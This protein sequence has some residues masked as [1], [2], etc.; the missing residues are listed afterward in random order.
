MPK[1]SA[2]PRTFFLNEQHELAP[3]E[4][5]GGGG[6]TKFGDIDWGQR[7]QRIADSL[8]RAVGKVRKSPD[9]LREE[10]YFLAAVPAKIPKLTTSKQ[11]SKTGKP[12]EIEETP[13]FGGKDSLV[14]RRLGVD[15]LQ[16]HPDGTATVHVGSPSLG[17]LV[18]TSR[19]LGDEG[20]RQQARLS[21]IDSFEEVPWQKRIDPGWFAEIKSIPLVEFVLEFQP[22]LSRS[23]VRA[24]IEA[25]TT[26]L[27]S[28]ENESVSRAGTDFSGRSWIRGRARPPT[29]RLFAERFQSIQSIHPPLWTN[30][31]ATRRKKSS[32]SSAQQVRGDVDPSSLPVVAVVDA[33]VPDQHVSLER[34]KRGKYT[35]PGLPRYLG[36]HGTFVASRVVFGDPSSMEGTA[37]PR[38]SFYDVMLAEEADRIDDKS[39]AEAVDAVI[40]NAPDVR[41]FNMSFDQRPLPAMNDVDR[42]ER[43]ALVQDLDNLIF[44]RDILVVV[45]AGNSPPGITPENEYPDHF[46]E[47]SWKL[48]PWASG[49]NT[50]TCGSLI[51]RPNPD[52]MV[53]QVGYPSP[54]TRSGPGVAGAPVPEFAAS[55]GECDRLWSCGAGMGVLGLNNEGQWED[56]C[57]TS[58]AAP[59]LAQEAAIA[60]ALLQNACPPGA[61]TFAVTVKAFLALTASLVGSPPA[62]KKW[63]RQTLGRGRASAERL[64][65]PL[66]DSAI[67]LW[68]TTLE[69]TNAI[70]RVNVPVPEAWLQA[71]GAARMKLVC[72]W[73]PPVN[74]SVPDV[75][76]CRKVNVRFRCG[77]DGPALTGKGRG[78]K[79]YPLVER[80]YD[81]S[82]A[83]RQGDGSDWIVEVSYEQKAE[84]AM[85]IDFSPQQRV[86]LAI[87]LFDDGEAPESPQAH[88]QALEIAPTLIRL[89][90][91]PVGVG[92]PVMIRQRV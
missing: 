86:A 13:N 29:L 33:G 48:G 32:A 83:E 25:L 2:E 27:D 22:V 14:F 60:I 74:A 18:S 62:A 75:W 52:G 45:A 90:V 81:L 44:A 70:A 63:V 21:S 31:A 8:L 49:L 67:F 85:G 56:R 15:L 87:E 40:G 51:A 69:G 77:P 6:H 43:L 58:Y 47:T 39:V 91:P 19:N 88:V 59:L 78:H 68:Q 30:L 4:P 50:L 92:V 20:G 11:H 55:G 12:V 66:P 54:F 76:C 17:R 26:R 3:G 42:R 35:R 24:V 57:G 7:G 16:V 79:S 34:F 9:P 38:C 10:R 28:D 23:D 84:Y 36:K 5:K 53:G 64:A 73:D 80:V 37:S 46:D 1:G 71:A 61:R 65:N 89:T 72:S 41:V 82:S